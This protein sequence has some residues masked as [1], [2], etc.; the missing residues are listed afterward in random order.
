MNIPSWMLIGA[1]ALALVVILTLIVEYI[2]RR[3]K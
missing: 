1:E 3:K 2:R